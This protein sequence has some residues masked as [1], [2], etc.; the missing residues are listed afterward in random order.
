[1]TDQPQI[2]APQPEAPAAVTSGAVYATATRSKKYRPRPG[3]RGKSPKAS[4]GFESK[5]K[6]VSTGVKRV[7]IGIAA[8]LVAVAG[9]GFH[10][11]VVPLMKATG[12]EPK[13]ALMMMETLR[14]M[15]S[16]QGDLTVDAC[17]HQQLE[18]S[19]R[20]GNLKR[21]QGWHIEPIPGSKN[22]FLLVYSYEETDESKHRAEWLVDVSI[23][24]FS[25][26]NDAA[27]AVYGD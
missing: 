5:K 17:M 23:N 20:V 18:T 14:K 22:T 10:T 11:F 21:Y 15:P 3:K 8:A 7:L 6:P 27:R 16:K 25:P 19:R 26:Q 2:A 12:P 13:A 1:L 9:A 4:R 24:S